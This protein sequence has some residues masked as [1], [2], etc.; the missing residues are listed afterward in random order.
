MLGYFVRLALSNMI[1]LMIKTTKPI[2]TVSK[3]KYANAPALQFGATAQSGDMR[4]PIAATI[5][6]ETANSGAKHIR[7]KATLLR[8]WTGLF[9]I[10]PYLHSWY[11]KPEC[12]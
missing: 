2:G 12:I 11:I 4:T 5:S 9:V 6:G 3:I 8:F 10:C 1:R 7:T